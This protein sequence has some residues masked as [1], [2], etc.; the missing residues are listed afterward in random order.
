MYLSFK[1]AV[2]RRK[3]SWNIGTEEAPN[4]LKRII[5]SGTIRLLPICLVY[6]LQELSVNSPYC[7][8]T[9]VLTQEHKIENN[10]ILSSNSFSTTPIYIC[11]I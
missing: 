4:P 11:L 10:A 2:Q 8:K 6:C 1:A 7:L 5:T 3:E 9:F